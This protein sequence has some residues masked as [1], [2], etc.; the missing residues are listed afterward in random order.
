ML[1]GPVSVQTAWER[2]SRT[3]RYH[4]GISFGGGLTLKEQK[5]I[6]LVGIE[7][8]R[9]CWQLMTSALAGVHARVQHLQNN[10]NKRPW[11]NNAHRSSKSSELLTLE[12]KWQIHLRVNASV[13][14]N[15][16]DIK[17]DFFFSCWICLLH[18]CIFSPWLGQSPEPSIQ[19]ILY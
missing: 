1:R 15:I 16:I 4:S 7:D 11:S 8:V 19:A 3:A 18:L 12:V 2:Q 14:L 13:C 10:P 5:K 6:T 17:H 9:T